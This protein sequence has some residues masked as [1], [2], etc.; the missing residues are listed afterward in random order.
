[1][2]NCA[3]HSRNDPAKKTARNNSLESSRQRLSE[4]FR[5]K[6][7]SGSADQ[8]GSV[9]QQGAAIQPHEPLCIDQHHL[10]ILRFLRR[11]VR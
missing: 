5:R 4:G 9:P 11:L 8:Q 3:S 6:P 7:D 10:P 2:E 1:M